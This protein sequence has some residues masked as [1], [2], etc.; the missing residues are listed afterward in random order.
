M[1]A[2]G[3][4]ARHV[5]AH[6]ARHT[7]GQRRE[8]CACY[9]K[10]TAAAETTS[11][12]IAGVVTAEGPGP[13]SPAFAPALRMAAALLPRIG[14]VVADAGYDSEAAHVL[15]TTLGIRRT[16]IRLNPRRGRKW[17]RTPRRRQMRRRFPHRVYGRRQRVESLFSQTKRRI[18]SALAARGFAHQREELVLH[19]LTHNLLILPRAPVR[20]QQSQ[21]DSKPESG[22]A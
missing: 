4:E 10:L 15:C 21:S 6:Y 3:F 9:P 13:D 7:P 19:V 16:A 5:S 18:S 20:F 14:A 1:D 22:V 12:L 17:P 2:T 11:H 8:R